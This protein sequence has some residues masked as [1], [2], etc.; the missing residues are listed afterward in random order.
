MGAA[1]LLNDLS[2]A[3]SVVAPTSATVTGL[4]AERLRDRQPRRRAR[5]MGNPGT[6]CLDFGAP[7]AMDCFA[8]VSTT[9]A[10][11]ASV[12]L[13]LYGAAG[14]TANNGDLLSWTLAGETGPDNL[15]QAVRVL[16]QPLSPRFVRWRWDAPAGEVDVG[17]AP[18]GLLLRTR[19]Q[20][21]WS[22]QRGR[23]DFAAAQRNP[24]TGARFPVGG[25]SARAERVSFPFLT[26]AE[27]EAFDAWDRAGGGHG[28]ALWVPETA[29]APDRLARFCIWGELREPGFA[30][31]SRRT[32]RFWSRPFTV[33]EAL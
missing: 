24:D 28:E 13:D 9:L 23:Q 21:D 2:G 17:L 7:R 11:G 19:H 5:F 6:L 31:A 29:W 3:A 27:A 16:A 4:G 25:P 14:N 1:F 30:A 33:L 32:H 8:L 10:A 12:S 20:F 22:Q 26:A 18:C 15:G